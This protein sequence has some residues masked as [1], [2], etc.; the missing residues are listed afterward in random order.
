MTKKSM[1]RR[2]GC[3]YNIVLTLFEMPYKGMHALPYVIYKSYFIV[4]IIFQVQ[5]D[6]HIAMFPFQSMLPDWLKTAVLN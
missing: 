1:A 6:A 3:V 5:N 4:Y 2:F